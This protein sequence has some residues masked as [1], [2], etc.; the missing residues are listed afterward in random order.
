MEISSNQEGMKADLLVNADYDYNTQG[1]AIRAA[2]VGRRRVW[3]MFGFE[4]VAQTNQHTGV[5]SGKS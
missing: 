5:P 2:K 4:V 3:C 1:L